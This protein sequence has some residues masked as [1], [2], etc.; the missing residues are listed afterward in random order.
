MSNRT[1]QNNKRADRNMESNDSPEFPD[2][3]ET[4]EDPGLPS[5]QRTEELREILKALNIDGRTRRRE[6][7]Q[8]NRYRAIRRPL[9]LT[10]RLRTD[11]RVCLEGGRKMWCKWLINYH[12]VY[13]SSYLIYTLIAR[14]I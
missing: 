7:R 1:R 3:D 8:K 2:R 12:S 13:Y 11:W 9:L 10:S 14:D 5:G 4:S 6:I